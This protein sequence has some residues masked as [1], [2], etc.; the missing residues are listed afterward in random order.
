MQ[1][2]HRRV[3]MIKDGMA[4]TEKIALGDM[5]MGA[6]DLFLVCTQK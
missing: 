4:G 2:S 1:V 5:V 6:V 3:K